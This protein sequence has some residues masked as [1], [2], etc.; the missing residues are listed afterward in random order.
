MK[1]NSFPHFKYHPNPLATGVFDKSESVC[2]VCK[3]IRG[4]EYVGPFYSF[5]EVEGICPLCIKNGKAAEK[6]RLTFVN[7]DE[8]DSV[9]EGAFV[10]EL[11]K[12]T[13]GCFFPQEDSWPSHCGDFCIFVESSR[14]EDISAWLK[15]LDKD[16]EAIKTRLGINKT[17][18]LFELKRAD[19]PLWWLLFRCKNC[20]EYRLIADYE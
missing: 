6:Y 3:Q 16:L 8:I 14:T 20:G 9:D 4:Y 2:P 17:E 12:R 18:L 13:P 5:N 11:T 1:N 19:S 10:D 15:Y 7:E